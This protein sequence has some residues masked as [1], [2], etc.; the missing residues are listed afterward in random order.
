MYIHIR[1]DYISKYYHS[2]LYK[3]T[4]Q[5]YPRVREVHYVKCTHTIF[6]IINNAYNNK[7]LF[8]LSY[9]ISM[10]SVL[11]HGCVI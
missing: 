5:H 7:I 8:F 4:E 3:I 6:V 11:V 10:M 1:V 9:G 2:Q